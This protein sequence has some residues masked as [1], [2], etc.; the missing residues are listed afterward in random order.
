[1]AENVVAEGRF[2][3]SEHSKVHVICAVEVVDLIKERL[4]ITTKIAKEHAVEE[5][6]ISLRN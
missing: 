4:Q 3:N 6:R 1:M 2:V 5:V